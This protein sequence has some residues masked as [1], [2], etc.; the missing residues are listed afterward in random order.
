[1]VIIFNLD[2]WRCELT[3]RIL[4]PSATIGSTLTNSTTSQ[5]LVHKVTFLHAC[6]LSASD[7]Q[8]KTR[9]CVIQRFAGWLRESQAE[10]TQQ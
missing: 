7:T 3:L 5:E 1:V 2:S 8:V 9:A 6:G 4:I 10:F